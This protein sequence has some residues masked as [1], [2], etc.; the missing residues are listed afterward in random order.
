MDDRMAISRR[1]LLTG[2]AAAAPVL[3]AGCGKGG[4]KASAAPSGGST[5][6]ADTTIMIIRHGEK[7]VG[8]QQGID[9][10]GKPDKG[11]LTQRGWE[12]ARALPKLFDPPQG[13]P[14]VPGILRP[15]TIYA[16]TDQGP[17]AGA[18]RMRQTVTPLAQQMGIELNLTYAETQEAQ[19]AAAALAAPAPVLICW[20]H[21]RIPAIVKGLGATG[22]GC[23]AKWPGDRFDL[24]WVFTRTGGAWSFHQVDQHLLPGDA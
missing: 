11:S 1:G 4:H 17:H 19:L 5:G 13:R 24:V 20:E 6:N 14:L 7:P 12:R 23:P 15:R 9:D 18:H 21:Q 3:L 16:A 10:N 2:M 22:T 8:S